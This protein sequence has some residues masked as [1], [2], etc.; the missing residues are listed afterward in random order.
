[1]IELTGIRKEF[2]QNIGSA[3]LFRTLFGRVPSRSV[4]AL[5]S[6]SFC[7]EE[8]QFYS[9]LGRNGAGK[10]TAIKILCTLLLP[11]GG[12]GRVAGFDIVRQA[13]DVRRVIGVSVRGE[14]SVYWRQTGRR[15]LEYFG[16]LY[17]LRGREL[18]RRVEEVGEVVGLQG[19]ID[20]YVERYS[21]GMKQR[22]AI[23]CALIH[24][25]RVLLLDEP[26]IGLDA[27]SARSLRTFISSELRERERVTVLYTTHY[28]HEA[29]E[30][31][32]VIGILREGRIVA[33]GTPD[34]VKGRVAGQGALELT[35]KGAGS[36]L[37]QS[38][39]RVAGVQ[40]VSV[41]EL[42][43]DITAI[44]VVGSGTDVPV[45]EVTS[46]VF[47]HGAE[48]RALTSMRPTLEDAFIALT[49]SR[50]APVGQA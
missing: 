14:R 31:S 20:D 1:M 8:G 22:L 33:E 3:G 44:R 36:E 29:E 25:P 49:E 43:G 50:V 45:A 21:M 7:V 37:A 46:L 40:T 24:R 28:M 38:I 23:G 19:R 10:T 5:N 17:D 30:M 48:I 2:R 9:L 42:D 11:D 12:S 13:T 47:K 34:Q 32:D 39:E 26:T 35:V 16:R 4:T 41:S 18:S 6:V 27:A 15:N